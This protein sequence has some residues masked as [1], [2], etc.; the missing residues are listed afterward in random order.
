MSLSLY[1][2]IVPSSIQ[3]LNA[4]DHVMEKAKSFCAA[5]GSHEAEMIDARLAPDMRP[6]GYQVKSCVVHTIIAIENARAGSASPDGSAWPTDFDGLRGILQRASAEL[7]ALDRNM[8]DQ[9]AG[10][11]INFVAGEHKLPF[12]GANFLLSFSQPNF[13]FHATTAYAILRAQGVSLSK[14]D[15]LGVLRVNREPNRAE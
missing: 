14:V 13:Y 1:D 7:R 6:L 9:L 10:A 2:A 3:I 15:F 12:N 8:V 4:L 11:D 5:G